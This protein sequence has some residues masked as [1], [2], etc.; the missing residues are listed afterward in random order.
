M[1]ALANNSSD[2]HPPFLTLNLPPALSNDVLQ[3]LKA[4]PRAVS[5]RDQSAHFYSLATRMLDLFDERD[6]VSVLRMAFLKRAADI[7]LHARKVGSVSASGS[8]GTAA[9]HSDRKEDANGSN[10]GIGATGQEFLRGLDE[11]ERLLFR[12]THDGAKAGREFLDNVK[13]NY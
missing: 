2:D 8:S 9:S 12:R 3:A 11:W 4:D 6:L 7:S 13:R 5:L 1:L 10:L